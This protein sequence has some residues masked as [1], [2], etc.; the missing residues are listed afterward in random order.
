MNPDNPVSFFCKFTR[1]CI[2]IFHHT[3]FD[4]NFVLNVKVIAHL[5]AADQEGPKQPQELYAGFEVERTAT[6]CNI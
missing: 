2:R 1:G 3:H 4:Q 5:E 6:H